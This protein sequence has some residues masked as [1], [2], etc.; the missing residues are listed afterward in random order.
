MESW[1]KSSLFE[2]DDVMMIMKMFM[3]QSYRPAPPSAPHKQHTVS[4]RDSKT[5][6]TY[7]PRELYSRRVSSFSRTVFR[8]N[9]PCASRA[10]PYRSPP[11]LCPQVHERPRRYGGGAPCD[12]GLLRA[13]DIT[14]RVSHS[15]RFVRAN[16]YEVTNVSSHDLKGYRTQTETNADKMKYA[17]LGRIWRQPHWRVAENEL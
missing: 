16:A 11:W 4:G 13:V 8:A 2:D 10:P 12:L 6:K 15:S 17:A 7:L 1:I 3:I 9:L 14:H 5:R